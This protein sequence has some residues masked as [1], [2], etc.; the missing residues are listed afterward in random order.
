MRGVRRAQACRGKPQKNLCTQHKAF[1]KPKVCLEHGGGG[2]VRGWGV[3]QVL[4]PRG[5]RCFRKGCV[6]LRKRSLE[7]L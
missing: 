1:E 4:D 5:I 3:G 7:R 6:P 2:V